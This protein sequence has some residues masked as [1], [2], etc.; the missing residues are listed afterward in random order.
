MSTTKKFV[1]YLIVVIAVYFFVDFAS[2]AYI[3]TTY[4][5]LE[6]YNIEVEN[7][8]INITDAKATYIN[9]YVKGN[10]QNNSEQSI[11]NKYV[12]LEF[13]SDNNVSLG[14]KYI[15]LEDLKSKYSQDF[16]VRFNLENVKSFKISLADEGEEIKEE[17]LKLDEQTKGLMLIG[18][19]V[20]LYI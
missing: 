6:K 13:F 20:F 1:I 14:K 10:L 3:K 8:K 4:N 9:G 16:E 12:K 2:F 19:L 5:D 18:L 17:E 15:K 11:N 7:P